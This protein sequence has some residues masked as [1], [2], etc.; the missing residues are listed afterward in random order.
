MQVQPVCRRLVAQLAR[1][2][3]LARLVAFDL[4][5]VPQ[6]DAGGRVDVRLEAPGHVVED[7][8]EADLARAHPAHAGEVLDALGDLVP[9]RRRTRRGRHLWAL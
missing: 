2:A 5:F 9:R 6:V 7:A 1:L 3:R 4:V 8:L